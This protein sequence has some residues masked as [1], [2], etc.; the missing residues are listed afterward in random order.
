M[1]G[2]SGVLVFSLSKESHDSGWRNSGLAS[3]GLF[4][5]SAGG[6]ICRVQSI[7]ALS[8]T[9]DTRLV[10]HGRGGSSGAQD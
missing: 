2:S 1:S 4:I 3:G 5:L 10:A 9:L 7:P 8:G 6:A